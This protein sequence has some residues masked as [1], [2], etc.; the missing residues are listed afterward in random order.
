MVSVMP[1]EKVPVMGF[2]LFL[3]GFPC[4]VTVSVVP[5]GKA[6]IV[7]SSDDDAIIRFANMLLE[8]NEVNRV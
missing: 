1:V 7:L 3:Y 8:M 6:E 5:G 4:D 2:F